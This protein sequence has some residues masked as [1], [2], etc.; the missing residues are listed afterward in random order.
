MRVQIA[1]LFL[2]LQERHGLSYL[3]ISHDL[4]MVKYLAHRI[5]VMYL[6]QVVELC[7]TG[8]LFQNPL[9]PYTQ[10]LI[11]SV[12]VPDP[13]KGGLKR[14]LHGEIPSATDPPAGCRF[15]SRCRTRS[16]QCHLSAA[17]ELR[18]IGTDHWVRCG[19]VDL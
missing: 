3:L 12:P 18:E 15:Q 10:A 8:E 9:H 14:V 4:S 16:E 13:E 17:A 11:E 6:G 19:T 5:A 2:A 7:K 1:D